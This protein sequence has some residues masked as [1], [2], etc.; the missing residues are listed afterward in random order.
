MSSSGGSLIT[1]NISSTDVRVLEVRGGKVR[2]WGDAPLEPGAV[3]GG[4]ILKPSAVAAVIDELFT[5]L[6]L[7]RDA[8]LVS[9]TG[10]SFTYRVIE[11]PDMKRSMLQE[12]M[13]RS[14]A[15]EIPV[16]LDELYLSWQSIGSHQGQHD[17]F[18]LGVP[19]E[20]ISALAQTLTE[21]Q[22]KNFEVDLRALALARLANRANAMVVSLEEDLYN[23]VL[24][25][26]GVP[27]VLHTVM[28]RTGEEARLEDNFQRCADELNKTVK[29]HNL[30]YPDHRIDDDLPLMVTGSLAADPAAGELLAQITGRTLETL[31]SPLK[32]AD[33]FPM[34]NYAVN[35]GLALKRMSYRKAPGF[36]DINL[37][38]SADQRRGVHQPLSTRFVMLSL[39]LV[40]T[41]ALGGFLWYVNN[42]QTERTLGLQQNLGDLSTQL[43]AVIES[44]GENQD[45]RNAITVTEDQAVT[46][47]D[48]HRAQLDI[49]GQLVAD[50]KTAD[51]ALPTGV[52]FTYLEVDADE[53]TVAGAAVTEESVVAY[54]RALERAGFQ[55]ARI[56]G[57]NL[58]GQ[59]EAPYSFVILIT[60]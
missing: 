58:T 27:A 38:V 18:L 31:T 16:S 3:R 57:I 29:F 19:R 46:L 60:P 35:L 12:A 56:A 8:V 9:L 42:I 14:A 34:E 50:F 40:V 21:A 32:S 59:D 55:S 26:R 54:A 30:S 25:S 52:T 2:V 24:V 5:R 53:I 13:E 39:A 51:R 4:R 47:R 7:S 17:Y 22:I 36:V 20:P 49:R 15:R 1:L 33:G 41:I 37:D 48:I 44:G 10:M 28:P 11:M 45:V 23:I 6:K 43:R